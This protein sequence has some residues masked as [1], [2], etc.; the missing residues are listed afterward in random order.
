MLLYH[1]LAVITNIEIKISGPEWKEEF[2]LPNG[3]SIRCSKLF[4][5]YH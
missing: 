4:Q 2:E 1:L 3:F 5:V